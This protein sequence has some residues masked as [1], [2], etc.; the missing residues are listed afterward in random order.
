MLDI[1]AKINLFSFSIIITSFITRLIVRKE[2]P[3]KSRQF[4][5]CSKRSASCKFFKWK[6]EASSQGM[7]TPL[8][9]SPFQFRYNYVVSKTQLMFCFFYGVFKP[10]IS[11]FVEVLFCLTKKIN[12]FH[13]QKCRR[14]EQCCY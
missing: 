5:T 3:N 10:I 12:F 6:D 11:K 13:K 14:S 4:Y 2:G 7:Y 8:H 9:N 1:V